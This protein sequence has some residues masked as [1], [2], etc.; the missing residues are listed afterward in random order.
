MT[1][2]LAAADVCG[3]DRSGPGWIELDGGRIVGAAAGPPP[4]GAHVLEGCA[5]VP[6]FVD[7]HVHGG[8]GHTMTTGDPDAIVE[9]AR[10]HRAHGTTTTMVSLVTAPVDELAKASRRIAALIDEP[11]AD[12]RGQVA[13]IHL[14]GP[15]LAT[16][17]CGAQNPEHMVDPT[18]DAV[19]ELI[20]AGGGH[21]RMVTMAPER[22]GALDAIGRFVAAGVVVAIGHTDATWAEAASGIAA[23]ATVATHLGNAMPTFHHREPGPIGA[24]L[25]APDVTCEL[26]VD[27]H[28]LHPEMVRVTHLAKGA[29]RMALVTDAIA[30][31]GS[32]DGRYVLGSLEVEVADGVARLVAGGSLAGST[33]TMDAA[34][35]NAIA[36]GLP[37]RAAI[38]AATSSPASAIGLAAVAGQLA[39]GRRADVVVLD[40]D[41]SLRAVLAAGELVAGAL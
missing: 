10:F 36:A 27:G 20:D 34:V 30:A 17:R 3:P 11:P 15:F 26:I 29:D 35:R 33:L 16:A 12:L 23:G 6:G 8:G 40:P 14:E 21:L 19:A 28:H 25:G 24:C 4:S 41:R 18:P 39:P 7:M 5:I 9:A 22:L 1:L 13:G 38:A 31:A 2:V 32:H 37:P